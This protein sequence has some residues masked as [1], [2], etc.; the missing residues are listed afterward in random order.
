MGNSEP[1]L[2]LRNVLANSSSPYLREHKNNPVTWQEWSENTLALAKKHQRLIFLSIGY[3]ACHWCHV[4]E[5]ESFNS[6]E[7]AEI[8]NNYFIP[9]K[10]DREVRPDLDDIYMSYVTATTGAGGWPLNVFLTPELKPVFGGT[11]WPGPTPTTNLKQAVPHDEAPVTFIEILSK[12]KEVWTTQRERCLQSS[13]EI[14]DQLLA[15]AGEGIHSHSDSRAPENEPSSTDPPE[16]LDLDLLDEALTHFVSR[17]DAAHGG[18]SPSATAPKFPTPCNLTFLLRIGAAIA[19]PSTHTRF[20]FFSP[21]PGILGKDSCL[22]AARMS[23]HTLLAMSRSGL[24]DQLGYGFHRYS[25]TTDWNL[26]HFEKMMCDNAQLLGCFCDAWALGRDPEILGT[27]YNLV[28]Y[29]TNPGSPIVHPEGGWYS[30]EDADSQ[31]TLAPLSNGAIADDRKEGAFYVWTLKEFQSILGDP[32]ASILARHFGVRADGNVPAQHDPHDEFLTQNVLHISATPSVLAKE[33][34]LAEE[35]VVRVIKSGRAKLAEYRKAKREQPR[36][37]TKIITSWNALAITALARA[38]NTLSTIDRHR[39]QRCQE[40]AEKAA[41]FIRREMFNESTGQLTRISSDPARDDVDVAFI[42]DYAYLTQANL[43]LYDLTL[44]QPYLD[45][46][47]RLQS[48]LDEQFIASTT[49]GYF[50]CERP[51]PSAP[52]EQIIRLKPGTDTALPSPN[53]TICTN[54]LY[55]S[56]Y[57]QSQS[58]SQQ[59]TTTKSYIRHARA[60][61]DAFAVEILQHPFLYVTLLGALVMEQVGVKTIIAPMTTKDSELRRLKG[62][63]RTVV[64]GIVSGVTICTQ[65]GVCRALRREDLED[66]D[67]LDEGSGQEKAKAKR[68]GTD[69]GPATAGPV[70]ESV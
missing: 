61:L 56:S 2:A 63:G 22:T 41:A 36:V 64:K 14:T 3:S 1:Q 52:P 40:A 54:L 20:G 5:R 48:Y 13:S 4:M 50:Q 31:S 15:F 32:N 37:D 39:A 28:E 55:L 66:V 68:V 10:L 19:R 25:V 70:R 8:L 34:G 57:I 23:L 47:V 43:A 9:I 60:T 53:G 18:F 49:G 12:M 58:P 29:F 51:R 62:W 27:I 67:E 46:A 65:K 35:E 59:S 21:L 16:P 33:F 17:Y 26:P 44:S 69:D 30:S 7:V 45:W 11:Y 38:A 6:P 42:D 24:R